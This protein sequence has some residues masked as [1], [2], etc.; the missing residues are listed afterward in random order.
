MKTLYDASL[1]PFGGL[2]LEACRSAGLAKRAPRSRTELEKLVR[3]MN[4]HDGPPTKEEI[5][6]HIELKYGAEGLEFAGVGS[7]AISKHFGHVQISDDQHE[8]I[9]SRAKELQDLIAKHPY[10]KTAIDEGWA[11]V[12]IQADGSLGLEFTHGRNLHLA[13]FD[14]AMGNVTKA[15]PAVP[16]PGFTKAEVDARVRV[17]VRRALAGESEPNGRDLCNSIGF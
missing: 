2:D 14:E 4:S 15:S 8:E 17:A 5:E 6:A 1:D 12:C 7:Y 3:Q 13:D 10:I 16:L 9:E 11:K